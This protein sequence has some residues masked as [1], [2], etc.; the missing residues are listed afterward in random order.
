LCYEPHEA[1]QP[2]GITPHVKEHKNPG[3]QALT[4]GPNQRQR[5]QGKKEKQS[6]Q[7]SLGAQ[8]HP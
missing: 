8:C 7:S 4:G 1:I 5:D 6:K 3:V 2:F